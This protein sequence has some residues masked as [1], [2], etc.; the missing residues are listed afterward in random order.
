MPMDHVTLPQAQ[1]TILCCTQWQSW[2]SSVF[3]R[4]SIC[5]YCQHFATQTDTCQLIS[6]YVH[7][8]AQTPLVQFV[9]EMFHKQI[10]NKSTKNWTSRVWALVYS[11]TSVYHRRCNKQRPLYK[12]DCWTQISTVNQQ[13]CM[14]NRSHDTYPAHFEVICHPYN[15]TCYG[16]RLC[17]IWISYLHP[18]WQYK[19]QCQLL[20]KQKSHM[21]RLAIGKWPARTLKFIATS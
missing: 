17:Q 11:M 5:R 3:T 2:T 21:K 8:E 20:K 7:G 16:Q 4:C 14:Q 6:Q 12:P 19:R 9:V 13:L 18:L 1:S 10:R 15:R